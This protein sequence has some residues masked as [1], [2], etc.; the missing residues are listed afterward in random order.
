MSRFT[1]EGCKI[2]DEARRWVWS[3][4]QRRLGRHDM[5]LVRDNG[6]ITAVL[7]IEDMGENR[8]HH[9]IYSRNSGEWLT[10]EFCRAYYAHSFDELGY[11]ECV[12][13]APPYSRK[14]GS[15]IDRIQEYL[16]GIKVHKERVLN[17]GKDREKWSISRES[18]DQCKAVEEV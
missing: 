2:T 5:F 17:E 12:A 8:C 15:L 6:E 16:P 7:P 18:W 13:Y 14:V 4:F 9:P 11:D 3:T 1:Y 10:A